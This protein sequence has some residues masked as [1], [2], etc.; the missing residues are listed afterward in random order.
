MA[1]IALVT[2]PFFLTA[3]HRSLAQLT[4]DSLKSRHSIDRI[5]IVNAVRSLS[6]RNWLQQ[7]NDLVEDNTCNIL[8]RAWNRGI[9]V[10]LERGADYVLVSNLDIQFHPL[11]IDNLVECAAQEPQA[12]VWCPAYWTDPRTFMGARLKPVVQP[13]V[14]FSCFMVDRRFFDTVGEFDESFAPAYLEDT[15]MVYRLRLLGARVAT[16]LAALCLNYDRGT[17]K[18]IIDCESSDVPIFRQLLTELRTHISA[19]DERYVRKWGGPHSQERFTVPFNGV[20]QAGINALETS[21]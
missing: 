7:H 11:C 9:R 12:L 5:A 10:A 14:H 2:V 18:G 15:D 19:N 17:I 20:E 6:D 16:C 1:K 21:K 4:M 3:R 13:L 8:A